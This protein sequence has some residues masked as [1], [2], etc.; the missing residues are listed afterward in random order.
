M[1]NNPTVDVGN[2]AEMIDD[3][4]C[5]LAQ[6]GYVGKIVTVQYGDSGLIRTG[7]LVEEPYCDGPGIGY[8]LD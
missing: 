8:W 7:R 5:K 1:D 2:G 4:L 6:M 3:Q